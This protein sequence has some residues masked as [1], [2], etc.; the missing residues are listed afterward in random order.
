MLKLQVCV[1]NFPN[2]CIDKDRTDVLFCE[3]LEIK[4]DF[5][6]MDKSIIL[7]RKF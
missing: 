3:Q 2:E 4:T 6:S 5:N 1:S 7:N